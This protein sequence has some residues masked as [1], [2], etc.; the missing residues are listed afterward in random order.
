MK[1][2]L[3]VDVENLKDK[4]VFE[5][6]LFKEGFFPVEN[7][8]FA[9]IGEATSHIFNTRT[10]ILEVVSKGLE[11]TPFDRCKIIFEIGDNPMEIYIFDKKIK[12]FIEFKS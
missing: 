6:H 12:E 1:V 11:N 8:S 7:E 9:Y 3:V 10:Y 2:A 5:K 4:E